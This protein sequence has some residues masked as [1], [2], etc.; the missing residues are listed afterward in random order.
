MKVIRLIKRPDISAQP[1]LEALKPH[2]D[3]SVT[4]GSVRAQMMGMTHVIPVTVKTPADA[5]GAAGWTGSA[6]H[7]HFHCAVL[8]PAHLYVN[9]DR[10]IDVY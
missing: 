7:L 4:A 2:E 10:D 9:I 8:L 3:H 6:G 1:H 5:N